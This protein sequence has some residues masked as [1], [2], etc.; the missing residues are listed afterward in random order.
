MFVHNNLFNALN[1]SIIDKPNIK[2][3][4]ESQSKVINLGEAFDEISFTV[5]S[6]PES[7]VEIVFRE[8]IPPGNCSKSWISLNQTARSVILNNLN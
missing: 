1:S 3:S 5:T 6:Y 2:P 7:R 8:C 4:P